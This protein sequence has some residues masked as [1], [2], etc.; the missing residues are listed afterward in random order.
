M[1]GRQTM[2]RLALRLGGQLRGG[3]WGAWLHFP[4]ESGALR[5]ISRV[6]EEGGGV[7]VVSTGAEVLNA[8]P[9]RL[10]SWL[11]IAED[12]QRLRSV[13]RELGCDWRE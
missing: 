3:E 2:G 11:V 12:S 7:R 8:R 5:L 1:N 10:R 4:A 13:L 6:I 9:A